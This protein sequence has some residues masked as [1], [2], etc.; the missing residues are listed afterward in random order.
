MRAICL[1]GYGEAEQLQLRDVPLPKM[2]PH[3]EVMV[4]VHAAG[5]NPFDM[6]LR[7]GWLHQL[8]PLP[9]GHILGMDVAG[10]VAQTGFDVSELEVGDRVWGLLDPMRPGSYAQYVA[11]PSW[12]LRR[13][14]ANLSFEEAAS[15]PMAGC[16]AWYGLVDLAGVSAGQRVLVHA[17]GGGVGSF[18]VQIAKHFGAYVIATASAEKADYVRSLGA[19]E[20]VD[21]RAGDFCEQVR[22]VDVVLDPIGGE[23]NLKSYGCMKRGGTLL[24]ILRGDQ[25]EMEN[26]ERLMAE[27]GV[28]TKVVAFSARPDIL[29]QLR[30]L[31]EAGAL[32]PPQMTQFPFEQVADAH[33]QIDTRSTL[34]KVVLKVRG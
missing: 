6:K 9:D 32:K 34:G 18:G 10:V 20:V 4:E 17:G 16:T 14:P 5:V 13:M 8:F 12:T 29:D 24:V 19:D 30:P 15:V 33:R 21:Y 22:D 7:R 31:F 25:V 27:H 23:T 11:A 28:T 2:A 3:N 26:R 1:A